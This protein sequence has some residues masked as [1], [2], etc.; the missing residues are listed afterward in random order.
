MD[1]AF[2]EDVKKALGAAAAGS[3]DEEV[4]GETHMP[5]PRVH[6]F[7]LWSHLVWSMFECDV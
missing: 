5:H 7:A 4:E 1:P 6:A 3:S 2:R